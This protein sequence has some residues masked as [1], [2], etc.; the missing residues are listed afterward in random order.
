M[1]IQLLSPE[2]FTTFGDLLKYLRRH[3]RLTQLE[4]SITVGYSEAQIGRLEK[5][6]RRPDLATLKALFIPALHLEDTPA[7]SARLLALAES[8]HQEAAPAPGL[9]PYKGLMYFDESDADLFFGRE[10]LTARLVER[11]M[12]VARDAPLRCLAVVG[13]SG[14]G[15]SSLVRAG[16]AVA[17]QQAGWEVRAFTPTA[18][19]LAALEAQL[20]AKQ[21]TAERVLLLVDQFEETFTLC[22]SET[23]R[24]A[25]IDRLLTLAQPSAGRTT[26]LIALRADFYSHCAQY[27]TSA[28]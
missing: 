12:A 1:P 19:P 5:N 28:K 24:L 22:H 2:S 26:V 13:A 27:N 10:A 15:K 16:L 8:A 3:E 6:Q 9:T 21:A 20:T 7:L 11:V 18:D 17:L 25:F 23:A 14:S 4:L